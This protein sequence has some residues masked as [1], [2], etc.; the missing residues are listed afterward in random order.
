ML[1]LEND[2][3]NRHFVQLTKCSAYM[4]VIPCVY[5][6]DS[7]LAVVDFSSMFIFVLS[8]LHPNA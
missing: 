6:S 8:H 1:S 5:D 7:L 2:T 4:T 3:T